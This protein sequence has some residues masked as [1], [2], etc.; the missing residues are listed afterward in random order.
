[1]EN[2]QISAAMTTRT[3][4]NRRLFKV[5]FMLLVIRFSSKITTPASGAVTRHS[6]AIATPATHTIRPSA[7]TTIGTRSRS[8]RGTFR[9]TNTSCSLR[10]PGAPSGRNR[11]PGRRFRTA[12]GSASDAAWTIATS[13]V[14]AASGPGPSPFGR[15]ATIVAPAV[16]TGTSPGTGSAYSNAAGRRPRAADPGAASSTSSTALDRET[17]Q[18]Q[19]PVSVIGGCELADRVEVAPGDRHARRGRFD[20]DPDDPPGQRRRQ[21]GQSLYLQLDTGAIR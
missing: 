20:R 3:I 19:V 12:S 16:G 17:R 9:S 6:S 14:R 13:P 2:C 21:A 7:S 4:Q 15:L 1:M 5:E 10:R 18:V 8:R 11:S